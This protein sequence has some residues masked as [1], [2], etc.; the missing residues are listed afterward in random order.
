MFSED[1]D[2]V[3]TVVETFS[4]SD[5][6][7]DTNT[8]TPPS[9]KVSQRI[10]KKKNKNAGRITRRKMSNDLKL[11]CFYFLDKYSRIKQHSNG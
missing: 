11:G 4:S 8:Q 1:V 9:I 10:S 5:K 3:G 7:V 2:I 6:G